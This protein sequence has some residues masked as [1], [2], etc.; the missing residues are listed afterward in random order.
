MGEPAAKKADPRNAVDGQFSGPFVIAVALSTGRMDWDSYRLLDDPATRALLGRVT[1]E[2]DPDAEAAFPAAMAG[3]LTLRARGQVFTRLVVVPRGEPAN[4]PDEAAF[5]AKFAGL[6]HAVMGEAAA[7]ALAA[8]VL[9]LD[10]LPEAAAL[11]RG[12]RGRAEA[13]GGVKDSG[14]RPPTRRSFRG[15]AQRRRPGT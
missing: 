11:L 2:V 4:F 15:R 12:A 5:R 10:A 14:I 9:R 3:K 8:D 13:R 7:E 1:V 6:T